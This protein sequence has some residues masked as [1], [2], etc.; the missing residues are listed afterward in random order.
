MNNYITL[1]GNKYMTRHGDWEPIYDKPG[2]AR[3]VLS[4]NIDVTWGPATISGWQGVIIGPVTSPGTGWGTIDNLR[5]S[6]RK[7]QAVSFTDHY[8]NTDDVIVLGSLREESKSPMWDSPSNEIT[9]E[10]EL[11]ILPS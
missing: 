8:S 10:V 5:T 9:V 3:L 11:V 2:A 7:T 6:V 4:G 1:D